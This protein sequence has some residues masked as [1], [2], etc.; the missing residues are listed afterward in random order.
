[1]AE[2]LY[3]LLRLPRLEPRK[4]NIPENSAESI[5]QIPSKLSKIQNQFSIKVI[6]LLSIEI[7]SLSYDR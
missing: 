3:T 4:G 7:L 1:M 2:K 6:E 5:E